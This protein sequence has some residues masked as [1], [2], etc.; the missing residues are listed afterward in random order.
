MI[1]NFYVIIRR[2]RKYVGIPKGIHTFTRKELVEIEMKIFTFHVRFE[3]ERNIM[4]SFHDY[5][6]EKMLEEKFSW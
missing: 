3:T 4:R 6:D 1:T 5:Y 2:V